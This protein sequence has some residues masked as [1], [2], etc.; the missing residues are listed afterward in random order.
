MTDRVMVYDGALPQT[1]DILNMSKMAMVGDAYQNRAVMGT[2]T[3]VNGLACAPTV[4]AS[5]QV[6]VGV[7]SIYQL[8]PTDA[9]AFGDLGT[10]N[11]NIVKQGILAAAVNLTITPPGTV[12]FSQVFLVQAILQNADSGSMVLSYY[13]SA[14][15]AAPYSGP[16]NSGSSN[17]TTRLCNCVVALKAGVAA[18]TG[19]Q[20][21]P[22]PDAGY[23]GLYAITVAN[24][25]ATITSGNIAQL[26]TAPFFPTLPQV[27]VNVQGGNWVYCVDTG[28]VNALVVTPSP[29]VAVTPAAGFGLRVRVLVTNT[30][31]SAITI[32]YIN[33][34]GVAAAWGPFTIK[35]GSGAAVAAADLTSGTVVDLV[36]DGTA[37]QMANYLGS[38]TNTNT[39]NNIGL[40][41]IA[42]SG[43]LNAIVATFSPA[44]TGYGAGGTPIVAGTAVAVKLANTITGACTIVVN[45][46]VSK[47][48]T[49]GDLVNPANA[50]FV[51]GEVLLLIYDGTQWQI[52]NTSSLTYRKPTANTILYV[53]GS[54]GSDTL[55]DGTASTVGAGT[56]GPFAT[57]Q[58]AVDTAF[59]YAPSQFTITISVATGT[60]SEKVATPSYAGPNII[61]DGNVAANVIVNAGAGTCFTVTGPNTMTVKNLTVQNNGVYPNIGFLAA[62]G[63]SLN[64]L[65]T[66]SNTCSIV[67]YAYGGATIRPGT[68]TFMGSGYSMFHADQG[69]NIFFGTYTFTIGA[70]ISMSG[71]GAACI[72]VG[73]G[74]VGFNN[75]TPSNF[76]NG[77]SVSA[78]K[79]TVVLNGV[80]NANTLGSAFLPG[81]TAGTQNTGGQVDF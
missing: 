65:N 66:V 50:V 32:N 33:A 13:N 60:Y 46:L 6:T 76:V 23:V 29:N 20:T 62:Q 69:G 37:F 4:P 49:T 79:Y 74:N 11:N 80:L 64:T 73:G 22:A 47:A 9:V 58:K 40:P 75:V 77:G 3:A 7:G 19:T 27:P 45:G 21:T 38:G 39:T 8:D 30:A 35:R 52:A 31:A 28:T 26:T 15:P 78:S 36:F 53:N 72:F 48:V 81:T 51:A 24:G 14:N 5:L 1:T 44:F 59:G 57:I 70:A 2:T 54:T 43:T 41:Y 55:R 10:D 12:G 68:H 18:T 42:D 16:N 63:S 67:F 61:V 25:A 71:A 34:S 56:S 17:Y